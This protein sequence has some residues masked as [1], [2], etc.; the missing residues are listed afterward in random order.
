MAD[1]TWLLSKSQNKKS[2]GWNG[3]ME[4]F[5]IH[6]IFTVSRIIPLP[7]INNP[8][9]QYETIFTGLTE[10]ARYCKDHGQQIGF[11]TFDLP[12]LLIKLR[13]GGFHK[14]IF[15]LG[16]IGFIMDGSDLKEALNEIYA[17]KSAEKLLTGHAHSRATVWYNLL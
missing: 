5:Y 2:V 8:L 6:S 14:L 16:G 9:S 10:A 7:F 4:K 17:E 3:L 15:F 13:L 1:F 11:T 12:L